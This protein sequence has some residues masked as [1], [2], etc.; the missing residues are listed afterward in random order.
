MKLKKDKNSITGQY[1]SNKK[2]IKIPTTRRLAKN[3]RFVEITGASGNNLNNIN[4]KIPT[5]SFTCVTGVS[6][7]GK[8]TLIL[9]TLYHALNLT[10][11]NKAR[12]VPKAFK[13]YKG[14]ELIDKIIDIDQSPIGRTPRS[15]PA[16][17]TGAFGPIR[18][19]FTSLP[20]SKTRGYKP[21]RFSFN[22]KGGRCEVC[23]GVVLSHMRC[24]FYQ[25]FIFNVMNVRELDI[26]ERHLKL[27]L[28]TRV[29]QMF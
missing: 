18:D 22:V 24:I 8:S 16:T 26:I 21:G 29:L 23:E 3:G 5:G 6:G 2:Y 28:K 14:V 7:S 19:W 4:L 12:K 20:E 10:L 9:Q 15:N 27:N 11:N 25:M 1:L 17:Y 13:G